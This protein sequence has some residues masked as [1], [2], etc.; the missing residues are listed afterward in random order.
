MSLTWVSASGGSVPSGAVAVGVETTGE[1]LY[2]AR[3]NIPG[4]GLQ[5]GKVRPEFK[6]AWIPYGGSENFYKDYEVLTNATVFP[7]GYSWPG[8]IGNSWD[9]EIGKIN[10]PTEHTRKGYAPPW[11]W[12]GAVYALSS[13]NPGASSPGNQLREYHAIKCGEEQDGTPLFAALATYPTNSSGL[14]PGKAN[15]SLGGANVGYGGAEIAG[16]TPATVLCDVST[17]FVNGSPSGVPANSSNYGLDDDGAPLYIARSTGQFPGLQLGKVRADGWGGND[18]LISYGGKEVA[19]TSYQVMFDPAFETPDP[20]SAPYSNNFFPT[21]NW[22]AGNNGS[23]PDG[24]LVLGCEGDG[25]PMF[26]AQSLHG[27]VGN[28]VHLGKIRHGFAGASIPHGG[29]EVWVTEYMVLCAS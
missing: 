8:P 25:T 1:A 17:G 3:V 16:I 10:V 27:A 23:I 24:A 7:Y 9:A 5:L 22:V 26:A 11:F 18:C 28:G 13:N 29:N 4:E 21:G 2:A 14:V 20:A 19:C 15:P 6:G 12:N